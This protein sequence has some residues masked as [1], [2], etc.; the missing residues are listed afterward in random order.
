MRAHDGSNKG[1]AAQLLCLLSSQHGSK[2][3]EDGGV[4]VGG[5]GGGMEEGGDRE[6]DKG[7]KRGWRGGTMDLTGVKIGGIKSRK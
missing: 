2:A 6:R 5:E 3:T 4:A 7:G 1:M